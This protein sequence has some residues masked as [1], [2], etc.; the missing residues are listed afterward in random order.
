M[1]LSFLDLQQLVRDSS[2]DR[3]LNKCVEQ[4]TELPQAPSSIPL[5]YLLPREHSYQGVL[6][7]VEDVL[8]LADEVTRRFTWIWIEGETDTLQNG[9]EKLRSLSYEVKLWRENPSNPSLSGAL[10]QKVEHQERLPSHIDPLRLKRL[11]ESDPFTRSEQWH[12]RDLFEE[13]LTRTNPKEQQGVLK[14]S[15][16]GTNQEPKRHDPL[17]IFESS[18][19]PV[20]VKMSKPFV[21][22]MQT[23]DTSQQKTKHDPLGIFESSEKPVVVK[24]SNPFLRS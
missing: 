22:S 15:S 10:L 12:K 23:S 13:G 11:F 5:S 4:L 24:I 19:K 14:N 16:S 20:M 17:G 9:L 8:S 21:P 2:W 1:A 3:W 6:A 7:N 18:E